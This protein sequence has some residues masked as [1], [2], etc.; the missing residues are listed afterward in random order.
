MEPYERILNKDALYRLSDSSILSY[1]TSMY[2][3]IITEMSSVF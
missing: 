2:C 1:K 3:T